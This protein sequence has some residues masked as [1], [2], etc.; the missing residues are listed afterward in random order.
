MSGPPGANDIRG[1]DVCIDECKKWVWNIG[2]DNGEVD[3]YSCEHGPMLLFQRFFKERSPRKFWG[4]MTKN[5]VWS[6]LHYH[7]S[8]CSVSFQKGDSVVFFKSGT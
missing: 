6:D 4:N 8:V 2:S 7:D 1:V 5:S 3:G